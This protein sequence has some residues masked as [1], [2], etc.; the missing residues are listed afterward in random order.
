MYITPWYKSRVGIINNNTSDN[1]DRKSNNQKRSINHIIA[2]GTVDVT[3]D[4]VGNVDKWPSHE[5]VGIKPTNKCLT[6]PLYLIKKENEL[7]DKIDFTNRVGLHC[8]S[9]YC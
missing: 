8:C 1:L 9:G 2:E 7:D 3:I 6:T 5:G 4:L